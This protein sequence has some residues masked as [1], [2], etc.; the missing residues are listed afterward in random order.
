[1]KHANTFTQA[2][3]SIYFVNEYFWF[4]L[5]FSFKFLKPLR[6]LFPFIQSVIITLV[7]KIINKSL[8]H[9]RKIH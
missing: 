6:F 2:A 9:T 8:I 7:G 1:M 3:K 5:T 4:K